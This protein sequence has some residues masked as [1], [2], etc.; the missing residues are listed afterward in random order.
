MSTIQTLTWVFAGLALVCS[1]MS[2]YYAA[3]TGGAR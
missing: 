1:G 3:R 2:V